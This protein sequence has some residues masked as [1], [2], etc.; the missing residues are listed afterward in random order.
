MYLTQFLSINSTCPSKSTYCSVDYVL[1]ADGSRLA[2]ASRY[3]F[4]YS[5]NISG[6]DSESGPG[7]RALN[8][9]W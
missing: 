1:L 6:N 5:R 4:A 3:S 2:R 8:T 7:T 9:G